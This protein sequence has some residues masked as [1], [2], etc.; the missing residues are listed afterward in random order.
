MNTA[1]LIKHKWD[2]GERTCYLCNKKINK[3]SEVELDH[4]KPKSKGGKIVK[5]SHHF[6][7]MLLDFHVHSHSILLLS[8]F[9]YFDKYSSYKA[10]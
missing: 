1:L 7:N 9:R 5:V 3:I 6:C 2:Q 8:A 4:V 10:F